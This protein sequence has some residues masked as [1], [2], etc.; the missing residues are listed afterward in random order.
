M[1][2]NYTAILMIVDRSGSMGSIKEATESGIN[3]FVASK[4]ALPGKVTI[5]LEHFD[6]TREVVWPST[7]AKDCPRYTLTPRGMT[8]LFDAVCLGIDEFG[9][10]L[11]AMPEH[12]RPANVIVGIMTDGIENASNQHNA[13]SVRGRVKRQQDDYNWNFVFLGANQ[14]AILSARGM[15]I[16]AG[17]SLTYNASPAGA[18]SGLAS[19]DAY[20]VAVASSG[21]APEFTVEQRKEAQQ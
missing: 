17:S 15:G 5:R 16:G 9:A 1:N 4:I 21:I 10:E 7:E 20:T 6:D 2:P 12:E 11:A 8:A 3:E 14:D 18:R 13:E 19:F